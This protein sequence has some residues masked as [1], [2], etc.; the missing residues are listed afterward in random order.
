LTSPIACHPSDVNKRFSSSYK[1]TI[2][3]DFLTREVVVDDR[4]VTM[5][6]STDVSDLRAAAATDT[7]TF[8]THSASQLWDVSMKRWMTPGL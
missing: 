4:L 2:G 8:S 5:Q 1:A 3:A 6:V 7:S